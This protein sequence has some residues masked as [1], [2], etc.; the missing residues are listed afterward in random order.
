MTNAH[1][2]HSIHNDGY[3]QV[4]KFIRKILRVQAA[5]DVRCIVVDTHV[6]V[7][8]G[9]VVIVVLVVMPSLLKLT[10]SSPSTVLR[11]FLPCRNVSRNRFR[12]NSVLGLVGYLVAVAIQFS[13]PFLNGPSNLG[14]LF[15][16]FCWR[17]RHKTSFYYP[18]FH[19]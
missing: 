10:T 7:G 3:N 18:S 1:K 13:K 16:L 4:S 14:F 17:D 11:K 5:V 12:S 9:S 2:L 8:S 6:V 19:V 15:V